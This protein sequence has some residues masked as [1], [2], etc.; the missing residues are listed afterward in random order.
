MDKKISVA[1]ATYNGAKYLGELLDSI[2]KQSYLPYE[3]VVS[4]DNST[5]ETLNI[6]ETF[7]RNAPFKVRIIRNTNQLGIIDNFAK[8]FEN[9]SGELIAYC[10][11]DDIWAADKLEKCVKHFDSS[12]VKLVMHRS[13]VVN[14]KLEALGYHIPEV[15]EIEIGKTIFPSSAEMTYGLGHQMLFDAKIYHDFAWIFRQG[16]LPLQHI[17]ENYDTQFRFLAGFNGSIVSLDD[18]L[19]KFRRHESATSDAGLVDSKTATTSGFLGKSPRIYIDQAKELFDIAQTFKNNIV[20]KMSEHSDRLNQYIQFTEQ[21]SAMYRLRGDVYDD[22]PIWTRLSRYISLIF[23]GAY[24]KKSNKGFGH[25]A[26]L[27]DL[28]VSVCGLHLAQKVIALK[29]R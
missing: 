7:S 3:L 12:D 6:I 14:G 2:A 15:H 18:A 25:K 17:A 1:L 11:Q 20:G 23:K 4:D 5:D 22:N 10:D 19:V 21:R 24:R 29:S 13:E 8:A 16:F 9:T 27:V 26:F 28:F